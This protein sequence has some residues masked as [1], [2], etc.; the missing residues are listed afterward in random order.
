MEQKNHYLE[1]IP[2]ELTLE[3]R[4]DIAAN[5]CDFKEAIAIADIYNQKGVYWAGMAIYWLCKAFEFNPD[6][7][8]TFDLDAFFKRFKQ[9]YYPG[10]FA[11][12]YQPLL[13]VL[14]RNTTISEVNFGTYFNPD[15]VNKYLADFLAESNTIKTLDLSTAWNQDNSNVLNDSDMDYIAHAL[16]FN[17]S[18]EELIL[19]QQPIGDEG[20]FILLN[21]LKDNKNTKLRVLNLAATGLS[22]IGVAALIEFMQNNVTLECVN[23]KLSP[24]FNS[25]KTEEQYI[26]QI[27]KITDRNRQLHLQHQLPNNKVQFNNTDTST[28]HET[29]QN[30]SP[31]AQQSFLNTLGERLHVGKNLRSRT[32]INWFMRFEEIC[33]DYADLKAL[34]IHISEYKNDGLRFVIVLE[35]KKE[36]NIDAL[37]GEGFVFNTHGSGISTNSKKVHFSVNGPGYQNYYFHKNSSVLDITIDGIKVKNQEELDKKLEEAFVEIKLVIS[38]MFTNGIYRFDKKQPC[39]SWLTSKEATFEYLRKRAENDGSVLLYDQSSFPEHSQELKI[40]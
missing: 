14:K 30:S 27:E 3:E 20:L 28:H 22:E 19:C 17:S 6:L 7:Q 13:E 24:L 5:R 8:K 39:V 11:E 23:I 16:K 38:Q 34:I 12:R 21:G 40:N 25:T 18:I 36:L 29:N 33:A 15:Y 2:V 37:S 35:H 26:E 31:L 10:I 9:L 4:C 1:K 32:D